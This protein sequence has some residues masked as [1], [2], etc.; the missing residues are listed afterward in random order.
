MKNVVIIGATGSIG[1]YTA[2]LLKEQGYQVHAV[3]R[4]KTDN[5]LFASYGIPYYSVEISQA[6][7]FSV[8][9]Q[10]S[11]DAVIHL[12]GAM[13]AH[14]IDYHP[15]SYIDSII[16]GTMN[17]LDYMNAI[18]C[19]KIIFS[20][21]IADV[22]YKF[23]SLEQIGDDVERKFPLNTDHSVYSIS[24]NAAVNLIEHYHAKYG[25]SRYILRLPTIY[26]YHA[27]P[28]YFVDGKKRWLAYRYIIEQAIKGERLE[29]WGD[30]KSAKEMVYIKDL[31]ELMRLCLESNEPGGVFNVGCGH[32]ISIEEQIKL[33][34]EV[35][36][37]EKKSDI[38]YCP[39]KNSSPQFV[40]SIEKARQQLGYKPKYGFKELLLD[41]KWYLENEPFAAIMGKRSDF[42]K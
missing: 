12:A 26:C 18:G 27:D 23:G 19:K 34:A 21:S 36:N 5:G 39:E 1:I 9:P 35:F 3:G 2:V 30:P 31:V 22:L 29:I 11:I 41:Y 37:T 16:T 7:N 42:I 4:R 13:P 24:K 33:I 8:L 15:Q 38:I 17:V 14:M 10:Q 32:P 20:Q 25:I 40:L 6:N 28:Y